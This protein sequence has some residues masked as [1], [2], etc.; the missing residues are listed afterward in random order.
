MLFFHLGGVL[1]LF[2]WVFGDPRVDV[3]FLLAGALVPDL[4]DLPFGSLFMGTG[5]VWAH[6]LVVPSLFMALV[7]LR[8][9]RGRRRRAWMALGVGWLLHLLLDGM[10]VDQEVFLWPLF[11]DIPK[12]PLP[13]WPA[14]WERALNDPWRWMKEAIGLAYLAWLWVA[15]DLGDKSRRD[16]VKESG[17]LPSY[18]NESS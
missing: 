17:R 1:W 6:S 7:L 2:R 8:T 16:A 4:I 18:A 15:L 11:G 9:R 14:A 3:R 10:W 12:G 13:F 5:E